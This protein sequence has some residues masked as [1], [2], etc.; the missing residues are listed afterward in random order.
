MGSSRLVELT[1]E[2]RVGVID[3]VCENPGN[4]VDDVANEDLLP[5]A[6]DD[7]P[8]KKSKRARVA[9][10]SLVSDYHSG[11]KKHKRARVE[12]IGFNPTSFFLRAKFTNLKHK[13]EQSFVIDIL[14]LLLRSNYEKHCSATSGVRAQFLDTRFILSLSRAYTKFKKWL[15]ISPENIVYEAQRAGVMLYEFHGSL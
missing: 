14:V 5:G 4:N 15:A 8:L 11:N 9:P 1:H 3:E 2:D 10:P 6:A 13:I 12:Q 7:Q